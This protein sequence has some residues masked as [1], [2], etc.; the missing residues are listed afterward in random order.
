MGALCAPRSAD[1]VDFVPPDSSTLSQA[2]RFRWWRS[3]ADLCYMFLWQSINMLPIRILL[4]D[5]NLEFGEA[6]FSLIL[7]LFGVVVH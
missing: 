2:S 5:D 7:A 1:R 3:R 4:V 6:L